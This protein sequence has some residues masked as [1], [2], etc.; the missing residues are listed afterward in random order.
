MMLDSSVEMAQAAT[1]AQ[2]APVER[3]LPIHFLKD[4]ID[5][6]ASDLRD[7]QH[8]FLLALTG[9]SL[10][11]MAAF[12]HYRPNMQLHTIGRTCSST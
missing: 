5:D 8:S 12:A 7:V 3:K 6:H 10:A 9:K 11:S 4:H 1:R 2:A